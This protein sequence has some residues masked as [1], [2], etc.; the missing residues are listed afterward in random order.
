MRYLLNERME[1]LRAI[2]NMVAFFIG[3]LVVVLMAI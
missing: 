3:I 1:E 2:G